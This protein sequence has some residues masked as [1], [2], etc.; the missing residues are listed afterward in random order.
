MAMNQDADQP[1]DQDIRHPG[2]YTGGGM[3]PTQPTAAARTTSTGA[4][5]SRAGP[6]RFIGCET[7]P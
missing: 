3:P 6:V 2:L 4:G 1:S 5:T 7:A